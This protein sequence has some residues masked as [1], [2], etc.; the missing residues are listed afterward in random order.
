MIDWEG[1]GVLEGQPPEHDVTTMVLV[2]MVVCIP[3]PDE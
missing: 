2:V 1:D 3:V